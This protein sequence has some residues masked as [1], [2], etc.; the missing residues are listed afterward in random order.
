M[1]KKKK[2]IQPQLHLKRRLMKTE[3]THRDFRKCYQPIRGAFYEF[4]AYRILEPSRN[5]ARWLMY[6]ADVRLGAA[7]D[8]L[9]AIE[10]INDYRDQ[11]K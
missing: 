2:S 8:Y 10:K 1:P 4:G 7:S 9:E 6:H 11:S 5:D 3:L